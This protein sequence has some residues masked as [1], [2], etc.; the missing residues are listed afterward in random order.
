M[1]HMDEGIVV[2]NLTARQLQDNYKRKKS[3]SLYVML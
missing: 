1:T 3:V 2:I